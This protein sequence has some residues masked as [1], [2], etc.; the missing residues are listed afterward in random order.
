MS[1]MKKYSGDS[2][3][4]LFP[5]LVT[6]CHITAEISSIMLPD[7]VEM[8]E[9]TVASVSARGCFRMICFN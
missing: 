3:R 5:N 4:W 2:P 6:S 1:K 8:E 9:E 7:S